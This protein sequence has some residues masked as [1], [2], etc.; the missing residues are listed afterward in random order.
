MEKAWK[1]TE[2][3]DD[4]PGS[5]L[6]FRRCE[7]KYELSPQPYFPREKTEAGKP[8]RLYP[9]DIGYR[10]ACQELCRLYGDTW[11]M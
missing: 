9:G 8:L 2:G 3:Y 10:E 11:N 1:V 4:R 6:E 7:G 5:Y